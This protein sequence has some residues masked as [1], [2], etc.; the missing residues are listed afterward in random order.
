MIDDEEYFLLHEPTTSKG[1]YA[2]ISYDDSSQYDTSESKEKCVYQN[3]SRN[4]NGL[5]RK[6][7]CQI[8]KSYHHK[9]A[10]KDCFYNGKNLLYDTHNL[11]YGIEFLK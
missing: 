3:Q 10:H 6:S 1:V 2:C 5:I 4:K 8:E 11:F 7:V 9:E